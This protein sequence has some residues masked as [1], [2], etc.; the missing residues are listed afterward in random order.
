MSVY[1]FTDLKPQQPLVLYLRNLQSKKSES[2]DLSKDF[3]A[4]SSLIIIPDSLL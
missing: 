3:K 4:L 1:R 2:Q